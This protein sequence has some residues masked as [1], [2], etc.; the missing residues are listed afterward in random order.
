MAE[1]LR[2]QLEFEGFR[3]EVASDGESGLAFART[4]LYDVILLDR[5]LGAGMSGDQVLEHLH[6]DG[7]PTPVLMLTGYPD[8]DSAFQAGRRRA[9]GYLQKGQLRGD[10]LA[11]AVRKAIAIRN[12]PSRPETSVFATHREGTSDAFG[13]LA[14]YLR[15]VESRDSSELVRILARV[16]IA[17]DLTLEEFVAAAN[18]LRLLHE[19]AHLPLDVLRPAILL[20]AQQASSPALFGSLQVLGQQCRL[21][22]VMRRAVIR[23]VTSREYVSQIAY[24]VGYSDHP[25]FDHDFRDFFGIT[26]RAFRRL[27]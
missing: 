20:W 19:K 21:G 23:L 8:V 15:A 3:V 26:P 10:E 17:P 25:N 2:R 11:A 6:H 12:Q 7:N 24:G 1:S 4:R 13:D 27:L 14:T 16:L 9:A 18:S 5:R 22:P